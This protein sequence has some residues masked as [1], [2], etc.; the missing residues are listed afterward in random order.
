MFYDIEL[1]DVS[2][3]VENFKFSKVSKD[4][5]DKIISS[6]KYNAE[7]NNFLEFVSEEGN[8]VL[9]KH[10]FRGIMYKEHYSGPKTVRQENQEDSVEVS[11][12]SLKKNIFK[13]EKND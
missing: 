1:V 8:V 13:G 3:S 11:K 12:V 9:S 2:D 7:T 10:G 6:F 4:D 5:L